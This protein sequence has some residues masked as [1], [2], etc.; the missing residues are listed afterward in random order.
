MIFA[1]VPAFNEADNIYRT[2]RGLLAVPELDGILVIDDGSRDGTAKVVAAHFHGEIMLSRLA[3][4]RG[5]GA[6]LNH[7]MRLLAGRD[8]KIYVF[9]DADLG[10]TSREVSRLISPVV[11]GVADMVTARLPASGVG[12]GFGLTVRLARWLIWRTSGTRV[13]A[14]L[15]GQR[16][17]RAEVWRAGGPCAPGFGAEAVFTARALRA[18]F[19]LR[20]VDTRMRHRVTGMGRSD[21]LHRGRQMW[22]VLTGFLWMLWRD[23]SWFLRAS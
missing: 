15:S 20:E 18:G 12:G 17:F 1:L 16:A 11:S 6:A 4:N 21:V 9:C 23:R 22:H 8:A 19:R 2:V 5:K 10:D 7:G 14:P 13:A 3:R